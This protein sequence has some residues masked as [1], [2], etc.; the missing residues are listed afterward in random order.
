[1]TT[2]SS[3]RASGVPPSDASGV[4]P[5]PTAR[6]RHMLAAEPVADSAGVAK[7]AWAS[8]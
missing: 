2:T 3:G 8:T 6:A 7:S 1:M 4:S 5:R